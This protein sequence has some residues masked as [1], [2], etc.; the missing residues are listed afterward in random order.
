M[1]LACPSCARTLEFSGERPRFCGFCGKSLAPAPPAAEVPD[2]E[3]RT[4]LPATEAET[5][6]QPAECLERSSPAAPETVGGYRLV[7]RLGG[8]GMGAVYEAEEVTSGRHVALKLVLPEFAGSAETIQRFRQEGRL[9]SALAHPRCVFVLAADEDAGRPYIVMELMPGATLDDLVRQR[10]PLPVEEAVAKILDVIEGLQEAHGRGLIHRDVKPSNC[11]LEQSGRV[12]VG[13]FGLARSLVQEAKLTRTGAFIGTPLYAA[14]EQIKLETVDAQSDVY[15]VAATL[16]FLLTGRAPFQSGDAMATLARIVSDDP[17]HLRSIR[18]ELPRALDKVVMRGLQR[19]RRR[20]WKNLVDMHRALL[21]FMPARPSAVGLGLR[22]GAYVFDSILLGILNG[23]AGT[24]TVHLSGPF[25]EVTTPT[26]IGYA[27]AA[28]IHIAYFGTMEGL[29]GW[30]LGKRL[31]RVRVGRIAGTEPPGIGRVLVRTVSLYLLFNVG[32]YLANVAL[33]ATDSIPRQGSSL[34]Q[35][36]AIIVAATGMLSGIWTLIASALTLSTMRSR[37]GYRG[38]HEFLSG[39]RTYQLNWP[40][41]QRRRAVRRGPFEFKVTQPL[42]MPESVGPFTVRGALYWSDAAKTLVAQDLHLDRTVW[43]RMRPASDPPFDVA[44]R[45]ISRATRIRWVSGGANEASQW[46]AFLVPTGMPLSALA[47]GPGRLSWAEF[48]PMLEDL[49]EELETA[50]SDGTLPDSLTVDQVWVQPDG[51]ALLLSTPLTGP[52]VLASADQRTDTERALQ[53]LRTV[54]VTAL[55]GTARPIAD[56]GDRVR[57]PVPR[58]ATEMLDRLTGDGTPYD[59]VAELRQNLEATRDRPVA[60]SRMRRFGHIALL[61]VLLYLPFA[62]P[63]MMAVV[64]CIALIGSWQ[65]A[66]APTAEPLRGASA[67]GLAGSL[68]GPGPLATATALASTT[69]EPRLNHFLP[70][71][72]IGIVVNLTYWVAWSFLFR[73]GFSF[74]WAGIVLRRAD[75]RNAARWQCGLRAL[76]VWGPVGALFLL[77]LVV[78]HFVPAMGWLHLGIWAL[79]ALLLPAYV[80]LALWNPERALHDRLVGTYLMPQ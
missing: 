76:L 58:H 67:V 32:G 64:T 62:G 35:R 33:V 30:S 9:A 47:A 15:S 4:Q 53:L 77:A 37:N 68:D 72:F 41:L 28:T 51:R 21:P 10:G 79:G 25:Y 56:S 54:A 50:C 12:K 14:P 45:E 8:G 26:L 39:T 71:V 60:V 73:G 24:L 7:R 17:P 27:I 74:W 49:A 31:L 40:Q 75:G 42:G 57:A 3:E 52:D 46:D 55:E 23:G 34:S 2:T 1:Q 6:I 44:Q 22:F 48:R 80:V 29:L 65:N 18:P 13:D 61:N 20:R 19:D 66:P 70:I 38:L 59:T 69:A 16:Y 63:L 11:F 36:Q 43:I 5:L 78:A